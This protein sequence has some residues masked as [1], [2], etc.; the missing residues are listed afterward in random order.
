MLGYDV[1]FGH[2]EAVGL[3][4]GT[5]YSEKQVGY[6]VTSVLLNES[7]EFLRLVINSMRKDIVSKE[8]NFQTLALT[9]VGNLGSKE[10]AES[11]AGDVSQL[12]VSPS[13]HASTLDACASVS[14]AC[15]R[16]KR[17]LSFSGSVIGATAVSYLSQSACMYWTYSANIIVFDLVPW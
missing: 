4:S 17:T 12:L 3:V 13:S 5:K 11:L 14:M 8:Q 9:A 7:N 16:S 6:L 15:R 1:E 2:M 10:F